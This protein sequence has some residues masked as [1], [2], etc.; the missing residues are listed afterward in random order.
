MKKILG[1]VI[2]GKKFGRKLGFPTVNIELKESLEGGV[3]AGFVA[4]EGMKYV[5][6][7]FIFPDK[8]LLEAHV[9]DFSGDLYGKNIEV[10]IGKKI[11]DS[12]KF[13]SE[14]DLVE[15]IKLDIQI[16]RN[17]HL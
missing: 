13:N 10:E 1:I 17:L 9:L 2:E 4:L 8:P 5:A 6:A 12:I 3:Y 14:K 16:I 15:Q 7:I 11:R